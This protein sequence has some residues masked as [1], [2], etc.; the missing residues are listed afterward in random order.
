MVSIQVHYHIYLVFFDVF[1]LTGG[2]LLS[3]AGTLEGY[4]ITQSWPARPY[5]T[6]HPHGCLSLCFLL[7]LPLLLQC[8]S[9]GW[10]VQVLPLA[11][12]FICKVA[13]LQTFLTS[14]RTRVFLPGGRKRERGERKGGGEG[15][16]IW[17]ENTMQWERRS[18]SPMFIALTFAWLPGTHELEYSA[19]QMLAKDWLYQCSCL[20]EQLLTLS[21][22]RCSVRPRPSRLVHDSL[23]FRSISSVIVVSSIVN[24]KKR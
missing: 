11:G 6:H 7:L 16:G 8:L 10:A 24:R 19:Q 17:R 20:N 4:K 9:P 18:V 3:L 14:I 1:D 23:S 5:A 21:L 2:S 12:T 22:S 15:K 13:I